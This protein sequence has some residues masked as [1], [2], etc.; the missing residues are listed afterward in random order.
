MALE[1]QNNP[2]TSIL[3][4]EAADVEALPDADPAAGQ[5]RLAVGTDH[6]LY[7]ISD[8]GVKTEVGGASGAVASDAIWDAAGDL[9][10]GTG[11][12]TAAKLSAGTAGMFL[13]SAGAAAANLWAYPPGYELDY[14]QYTSAVTISASSEATANTIVTGGSV[15][16]DGSTIIEIHFYAPGFNTPSSAGANMVVC[17][18]DGSSSIGFIGQF[19]TVANAAQI[20]PVNCFVRITPSNASHAYSIRAYLTTG[21]GSV[22]GGSGGAAAYRPGYV[23]I[24]KV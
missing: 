23:R 16:Y 19:S 4:V 10:Q 8:S 1:A 3:M 17:L 14:A 15:A 5:R 22:Y 2:F 21:T 20:S 9:V 6:L 12:N 24:T 13:K 11:A 7:L 18:Y